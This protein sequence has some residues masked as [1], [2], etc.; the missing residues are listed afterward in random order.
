[1]WPTILYSTAFLKLP[2]VWARHAQNSKDGKVK[3]KIKCHDYV[4][5]NTKKFK[6]FL[7]SDI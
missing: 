7:M 5:C 6:V 4:L 1:M 2:L 3:V